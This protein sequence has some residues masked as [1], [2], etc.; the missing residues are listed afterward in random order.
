MRSFDCYKIQVLS[1]GLIQR[2]RGIWVGF[3]RSGGGGGLPGQER[4]KSFTKKDIQ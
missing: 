1:P 3:N 2:R 4:A